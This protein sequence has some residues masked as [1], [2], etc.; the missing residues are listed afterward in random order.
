[1]SVQALTR[2]PT[3]L[4][5]MSRCWFKWFQLGVAA[6]HIRSDA[7]AP[8]T[9][10]RV[11]Q[12]VRKPTCFV[13]EWQV[14][15]QATSVLEEAASAVLKVQGGRHGFVAH[16]INDFAILHDLVTDEG[17]DI[18][19]LGPWDSPKTSL[20][21]IQ[22]RPVTRTLLTVL[23]ADMSKRKLGSSA[24]TPENINLGLDRRLKTCCLSVC[25]NGG[26]EIQVQVA[27]DV[28]ESFSYFLGYTK[29][30]SERQGTATPSPSLSGGGGGGSYR[31][32]W[33]RMRR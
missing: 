20:P 22:L 29:E 25:L 14:V 2:F 19:S 17:Q 21:T 10:D 31:R 4:A 12:P 28:K 33:T 3:L 30:Q 18:R 1:M 8:P 6:C 7:Q 15:Q 5:H 27:A 13:T 9:S 23:A 16:S 32:G 26:P 11:L 24:E